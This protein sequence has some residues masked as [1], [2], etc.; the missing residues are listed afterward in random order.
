M[1]LRSMHVRA[2][3]DLSS[4]RFVTHLVQLPAKALKNVVLVDLENG[5]ALVEDG[6]HNHA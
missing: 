3:N 4:F 5:L 6:V 2:C 1:H